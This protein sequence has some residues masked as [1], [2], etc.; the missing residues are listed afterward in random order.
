MDWIWRYE[1]LD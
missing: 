1:P